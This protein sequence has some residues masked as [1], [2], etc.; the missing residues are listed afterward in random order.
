MHWLRFSRQSKSGFGIM[1]ADSA[2]T[3]QGD[4]FS[5]WEKTDEFIG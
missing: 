2:R 1:E 3:C 4:M 5:V